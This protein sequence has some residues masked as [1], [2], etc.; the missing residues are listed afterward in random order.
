[1]DRMAT[2]RQICIFVLGVKCNRLLGVWKD[3]LNDEQ[4]EEANDLQLLGDENSPKRFCRVPQVL[5]SAGP[6]LVHE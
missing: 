6:H 4:R 1:M 5:P 3:R 2:D